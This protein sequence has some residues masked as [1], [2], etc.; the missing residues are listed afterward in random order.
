MWEER[1]ESKLVWLYVQPVPDIATPTGEL[2]AGHVIVRGLYNVPKVNGHE[3]VRAAL[4]GAGGSI[5]GG[6]QFGGVCQ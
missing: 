6:L 4:Y 3:V 1:G 2:S 5:S